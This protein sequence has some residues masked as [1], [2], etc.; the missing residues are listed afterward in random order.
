VIEALACGS[1]VVATDIPV[2]REVGGNAV[3]FCPLTR[4]DDWVTVLENHLQ[5]P[6]AQPSKGDRLAQAAKYS[7]AAHA[8]TISDAYEQLLKL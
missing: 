2:L 1:P 4:I 8:K 5:A 3:T 7:W 6:N